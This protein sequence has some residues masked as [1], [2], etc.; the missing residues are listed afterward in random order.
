MII[1]YSCLRI[2][3]EIILYRTTKLNPEYCTP[4]VFVSQ[5]TYSC[6]QT[7]NKLFI[8]ATVS[9]CNY[10]D[11]KIYHAE[12]LSCKFNNAKSLAWIIVAFYN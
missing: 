12:G 4:Y 11:S 7:Q 9:I 1:F 8:I 10:T 5:Y 2:E 6:V 3:N